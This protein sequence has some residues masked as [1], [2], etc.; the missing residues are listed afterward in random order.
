MNVKRTELLGA[1]S[2]VAPGLAGKDTIEQGDCFVFRDG[3][4]ITYN[5]EVALRAKSPLD[6]TGAVIAAPLLQLLNK[7]EDDELEVTMEEGELRLKG[8]RKRGGVK[9]EAAITLPLEGLEAPKK[10]FALHKDFLEGLRIVGGSCSSDESNFVITCVHI[11]PSFVEATDN[12]QATRFPMETGFTKDLTLPSASVRKLITYFV[13]KCCVGEEWIH[14]RNDQGLLFSCRI[15][16]DT[17]PDL[18]SSFKFK[19]SS[20]KLPDGLR[21]VVSRAE[22]FVQEQDQHMVNVMLKGPRLSLRGEGS[23]G[24]YEETRKVVYEGEDLNFRM[25]SELLKDMAGRE[26]ECL[27]GQNKMMVK[28][29]KYTHLACLSMAEEKEAE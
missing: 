5:D 20:V 29:E 25:S 23:Q 7:M 3:E 22:V 12:F 6:I 10:F 28:T 26:A 9:M 13:A 2:L 18:T 8:K 16:F 14:F 19:G 11:A 4:V 24:W 17:Y 27:V 21:E 15:Y 1:L